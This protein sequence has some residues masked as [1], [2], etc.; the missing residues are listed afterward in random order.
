MKFNEI[1][2]GKLYQNKEFGNVYTKKD[3]LLYHMGSI[4]AEFNKP[5]TFHV[6]MYYCEYKPTFILDM[7]FTEI[8]LGKI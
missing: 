3:G 6:E 7:D 1:K 4:Y 2:D 5:E 8:R